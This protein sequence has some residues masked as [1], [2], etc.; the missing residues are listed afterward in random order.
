MHREIYEQIKHFQSLEKNDPKND[1]EQKEMF[2]QNF[3]WENSDLTPEQKV[4]VENLLVEFSDIFAKHRFDVGYNTELKIKLTPEHDMP[5]YVQS[6]ITPIHLRDELIVELALMHYFNLVTTL[7]HSKYSSPVFAQRKSSGKLRILIDL[8]R[9]NHLLRNDY[10]NTNFPIS[11]MSDASNHFAGKTLFTKLDCSQAYHCV[12]MADDLSVQL[13]AFNFAS[14]TCAYKCLAQGL[15]KYVTGFSAFI[16]H[17]LDPRLAANICTQY[18]DD[19][20]SDIE[21][22]E[23]LIPSLTKIFECV[24]KPGLKLSPNKCEFV[25]QKVTFLGKIITP[26]GIQPE[27]ERI[28]KFLSKLTMPKTVKQ[29]KRLIGFLQFWR[30]FIPNLGEKLLPFYK[31]LR[32]NVEH[33]ITDEHDKNLEILKTD[34]QKATNLTLRLAKPGLQYVLLCDA[35][36]YGSGFVLM[37]EDYIL[38][39]KNKKRKLYAPVAFGTKL[40]NESQLKFSTYYKEFLGLYFALDHF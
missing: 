32:K 25:T 27:S 3:K 22:F 34:L 29:V 8:R 19:I 1:C 12:Q 18:M 39:Q 24:R 13:L 35:S 15:S 7:S 23:D 16:R 4:D 20:G 26:A 38:D 21:K 30:D 37:I 40:F 11:N 9:I 5:V 2:L 28:K 33:F 36:Y 17:Y 31:L 10:I 6:P 14:R